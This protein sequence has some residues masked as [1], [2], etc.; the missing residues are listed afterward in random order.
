MFL[1]N[2]ENTI[3]QGLAEG[4]GRIALINAS[5]Q[6]RLIEI[7]DQIRLS[8]LLSNP[9][10]IPENQL[11][12][13][14]FLKIESLKT[15]DVSSLQQ[16]KPFGSE[17]NTF[18]YSM[19]NEIPIKS[20]SADQN[21]RSAKIWKRSIT[22]VANESETVPERKCSVGLKRSMWTNLNYSL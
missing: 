7:L 22:G 15:L 21:F 9:P 19:V 4:H 14:P 13:S 3:D 17:D 20:P 2:L 5:N 12:T 1:H 10:R 6:I 16:T 8:D 11:M 18:D